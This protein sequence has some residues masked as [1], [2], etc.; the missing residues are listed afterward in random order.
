MNLLIPTIGTRGDI[1]P[2]I[3][4][5]LGLQ[6]AGY[7]PTLASHPEMRTL[8]ESYDLPFAPIGPDIDLGLEA[9]RIREHSFNFMIGFS[10][11][12]K[13][14]FSILEAAHA[15]LLALARTTDAIIVSHSAAGSIEADE[16]HLPSVSVTLFPQAIPV[17]NPVDSPVKKALLKI[18][19]SLMGTMM[20][21][22]LDR[23]RQRVGIA[24]MGPFG[25]TSPQLNLIPLSP[26]VF[27]PNPYWEPRH[28]MTGYW[29]APAPSDWQPSQELQ[30]FLDA[31]DPPFI[32]SLGAMAISGKDT[33]QAADI[34]L[35]AIAQSGVRAVIQGWQQVFKEIPPPP[36]VFAGGSLPHEWLLPRA[37][38]IIHHG[39]FGT[40]SAGFKAGIPSLAIP[41]I[42]DQF[43]WGQ[44]IN[45]LGVGPKPIARNKL[46]ASSLAAAITQMQTDTA[47]RQKAADLGCQIRSEDGVANAVHLIENIL[48]K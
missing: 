36:N 35:K 8:V 43:M 6:D 5:A 10:R 31:G 27:P 4:L 3:A 24:S 11:V 48:M 40:T 17:N 7:R 9:A 42:I 22:P 25:I 1:Q 46:T 38:G 14:S 32:V 2:Y 44:Q 18:A 34:T 16:L 37:A 41:H 30:A 29:F 19:G 23:I 47:M 12:M 15:D 39:G 45:T 28:Q 20:T 26:Y 21:Q 33:A 13:F